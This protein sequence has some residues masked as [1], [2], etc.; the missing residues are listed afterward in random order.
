MNAHQHF[1]LNIQPIKL[2]TF[3]RVTQEKGIE[4]AISAVMKANTALN[5]IA[6]S[7]DIYGQI[8]G[9]YRTDFYKYMEGKP[10][11]IKY[12]GTVPFSL[13]TDVLKNYFALLFPT[14][15]SGE[16]FPGTLLD[17]MAAGVP[18]IASDW[19]YNSEIINDGYNGIILRKCD[20]D[21]IAEVLVKSLKDQ[22]QLNRMKTNALIEA[23]KHLPDIVIQILLCRLI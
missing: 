1:N 5:R 10:G 16:G 20:A 8:D 3:S 14:Y 23:Q 2:C 17:A 22:E 18:V 6:F 9:A 4:L 11:Y 15:Y 19:K 7:L 21:G 12:C 13:S